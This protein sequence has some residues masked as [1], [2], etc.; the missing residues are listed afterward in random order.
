MRFRIG[1]TGFCVTLLAALSAC[2]STHGTAPPLPD[3]VK[4]WSGVAPGSEGQTGAETSEIRNEP[5]G[6]GHPALSFRMISNVNFP[7]VTPF[8]P[9]KDKATGVAVIIAPGGGHQFLAIDH[10]GYS[11]GRYLADHGIAGF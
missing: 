3:E 8:L 2:A 9:A 11:V 7:S 5:A 1:R 6:A 4:L 10:E